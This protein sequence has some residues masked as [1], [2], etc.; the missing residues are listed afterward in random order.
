MNFPGKWL[1]I[2]IKHIAILTLLA[3]TGFALSAG[4]SAQKA[5]NLGPE[6]P[7]KVISVTVWLNQHNK[8]TLDEL[9]REMYRPGSPLIT[10][11]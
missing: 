1:C 6:D 11:S 8:A 7:S 10:I 5:Q 9:V 3:V 4:R 2:S